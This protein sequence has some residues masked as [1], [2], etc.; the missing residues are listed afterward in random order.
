[1]TDVYLVAMRMKIRFERMCVGVREKEIDTAK[2][3][4]MS[5]IKGCTQQSP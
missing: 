4:A 3:E 2:I 1:M 5:Y